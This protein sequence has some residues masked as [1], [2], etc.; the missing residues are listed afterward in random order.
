MKKNTELTYQFQFSPNE[1]SIS[2][3]YQEEE[4]EQAKSHFKIEEQLIVKVF[5]ES[6][7]SVF[8]LFG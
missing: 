7:N 2:N 3:Q 6:Q 1:A 8:T 4:I 5:S